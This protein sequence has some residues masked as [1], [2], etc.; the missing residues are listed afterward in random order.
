MIGQ[1]SMNFPILTHSRKKSAVTLALFSVIC[2]YLMMS[3]P[4]AEAQT[5]STAANA[6]S[7]AQIP[8]VGL[9][10]PLEQSVH[11]I[12]KPAA[13]PNYYSKNTP[14]SSGHLLSVTLALG[15]IVVL[16]FG[17]SWFIRRFGQGML[18]GNAHMK[19]IAAMP[20]G[21]R[22]RILLVEV[23]GKQLLL[24]VTAQQV[25]TLHVFDEPVVTSGGS[26][27]HTEFSRKLMAILQQKPGGAS[28][29]SDNN[30]S[31]QG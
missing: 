23:G 17:V 13:S 22:E 24:G 31:T 15:L 10:E 7:A 30:S 8:S 9:E 12:D 16:I 14:G 11:T 1:A 6:S 18:S 21:T 20:L 27:K 2:F 29:A 3:V 5:T 26:V 28:T 19:M 4:L 25:N